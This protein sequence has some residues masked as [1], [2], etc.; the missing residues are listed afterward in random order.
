MILNRD[1]KLIFTCNLVG[2]F[3]DG[4][5]AYL[6]P[7][8]MSKSLGAGAVEIG[9]LYA[10]LNLVA[11]LTLFMAGNLADRYDRKKIM[12]AGWLAWLPVPLIFSFAQD[13][14]QMLPG[15][16]MYGFWLGGPTTTAY[17]VTA[18]DKSR[19]TLTFTTLSAAWSIGYIFSPALGGFLAG[20]VGMKVV[21]YMA[22]ILYGLACSMLFF[23]SSQRV[24]T[25]NNASE[26]N[27]FSVLTLLREKK[28]VRFSVFFASLMFIILMFRPFIPTFVADVYKYSDFEIGI[29]GSMT[30]ASSAVFAFLLGRI[31]DRSGK[32]QAL[33]LSLGL[34]SVSLVVLLLSGN[35]GALVLTF[36]LG[37]SS[38][39]TWSLM[40]A[41]VG[42][43]APEAC[44]A[45]WI[46]IPQTVSM[47]ASFV[48]PYV[49]GF[50]YAVSPQ[51][52]FV[53]AITVGSPLALLVAT[54]FFK[55]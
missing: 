36:L 13:W 38:Y 4:L 3:G 12:I 1:L 37:G 46:A 6:L 25:Y 31:G 9:V 8:Y 48:A 23:I 10:T 55:D 47:F 29:L 52:P 51:Y 30:F 54:G 16:V 53:V 18:V 33:A 19:L 41:I 2:S 20:I 22:F 14:I 7:V 17:V 44:R 26:E 32:S 50:L 49:G 28:L 24:R 27:R 34:T 21:F 42:P 45:R 39:V 15:M 5:F 35:F 40:S 11:A 43:H